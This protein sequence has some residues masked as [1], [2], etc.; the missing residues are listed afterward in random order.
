MIEKKTPY[1]ETLEALFNQNAANQAANNIPN[2]RNDGGNFVLSYPSSFEDIKSIIDGLKNGCSALVSSSKVS[3]PSVCQRMLDYLSG[4]AYALGCN[5][6][7]I[8]EGQYLFTA[9]GVAIK[10]NQ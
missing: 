7:K 8:Q 6:R 5:V 9:N 2:Q 3:K 10:I 1:S 4:A